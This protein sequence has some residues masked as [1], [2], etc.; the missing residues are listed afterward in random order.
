M[1]KKGKIMQENDKRGKI[2]HE[3]DKKGQN[4]ARE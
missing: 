2:M 4:G 3:N 1:T